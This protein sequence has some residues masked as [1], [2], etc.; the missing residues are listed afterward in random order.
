MPTRGKDLLT[1][2]RQLF[3][4]PALLGTEFADIAAVDVSHERTDDAAGWAGGMRLEFAVSWDA[5]RQALTDDGRQALERLRTIVGKSDTVTVK[6]PQALLKQYALLEK[7]KART[8]S[9]IV[10]LKAL[11]ARE[12]GNTA[13]GAHMRMRMYML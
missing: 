13:R 1:V 5:I 8:Q 10:A 6:V 12:P 4:L 3:G 2:C 7:V 11:V 9:V